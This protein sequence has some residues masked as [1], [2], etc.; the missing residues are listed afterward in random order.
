MFNTYSDIF[1]KRG[2]A[3][4]EAM[5][6][7]PAARDEEFK[8]MIDLL[9]PKDGHTI[10]DMPSG[11]GYLRRYLTD[12]KIQLIAIE[13]TQAF[14]EQCDRDEMT[15]CRLCNLNETELPSNSV[16]AVVS[17]AGMHHVEDRPAVFAEIRRILKPGGRLCI[18]DVKKGSAMDGFLNTFVNE[19]N[20]MGHEGRFIDSSFRQDLQRANFDISRDNHIS[21]HWKFKDTKE[22]VEFCTLMFGLD[23]AKPDQILEGIRRWQGFKEDPSSCR[24]NWGLQFI[25]CFKAQ[26]G[27]GR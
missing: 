18:A 4:H 12:K 2:A 23:K 20:S 19:H 11:G 26:K 10:A 5:K 16:E 22:M 3:Y 24:M 25:C 1:N 6:R 15:E 17:M 7:W 13:T 27:E 21:Y 8:A 14:Y 9:E